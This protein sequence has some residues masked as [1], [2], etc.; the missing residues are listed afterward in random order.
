MKISYKQVN[1]SSTVDGV[2]YDHQSGILSVRFLTGDEYQYQGISPQMAEAFES[3]KSM[4]SFI[5]KYLKGKKP[6]RKL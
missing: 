2:H 4:G 5:H 1:R 6:V 3:S